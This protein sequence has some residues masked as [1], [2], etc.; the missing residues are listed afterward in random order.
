V[1]F[2]LVRLLKAFDAVEA[3]NEGELRTMKKGIGLTMCE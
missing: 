3:V 1:G 2:M